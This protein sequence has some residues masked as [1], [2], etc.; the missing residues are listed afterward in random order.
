MLYNAAVMKTTRWS[1]CLSSVRAS[2]PRRCFQPGR[3][4]DSGGVTLGKRSVN[5]VIASQIA[6][7]IYW[8]RVE[9]SAPTA[10]ISQHPPIQP[11]V[12]AARTGPNWLREFPRREKIMAVLMLAVGAEQNA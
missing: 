9:A 12:A 6:T 11:T 4:A 2:Q 8:A 5:A 7:P 1:G 3:W 10:L